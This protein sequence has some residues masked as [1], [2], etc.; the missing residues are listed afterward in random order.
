VDV[1]GLSQNMM[2]IFLSGFLGDKSIE[3]ERLETGRESHLE[4]TVSIWQQ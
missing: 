2:R 1:A 4:R 3:A